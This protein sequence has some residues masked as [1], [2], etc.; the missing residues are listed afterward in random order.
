VTSPRWLVIP[1]LL[2]ALGMPRTAEPQGLPITIDP[3]MTKGAANAPVTIVEF[4]DYQ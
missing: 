3:I 1:L 4:S 2:M